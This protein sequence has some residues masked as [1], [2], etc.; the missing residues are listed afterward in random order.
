MSGG[1]V[2]GLR[3]R[4]RDGMQDAIGSFLLRTCI[5]IGRLLSSFWKILAGIELCFRL[6]DERDFRKVVLEI[7]H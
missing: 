7:I 5:L 1:R 6:I 3:E 4:E 2:G